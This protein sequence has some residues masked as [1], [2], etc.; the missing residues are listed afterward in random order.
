[1]SEQVNQ[2]VGRRVL[3][4][5]GKLAL[6]VLVLFLAFMFLAT[7][8]G[9]GEIEALVALVFGW[10][11]F[12]QRTVPS[13]TWNWDLV[14]MAALCVVLIA[15][16][17]HRFASWIVTSIAN[18]SGKNWGWPWRWTWCGLTVLGLMF[19][20]GMSVGGA[21]H[22]IGWIAGSQEAWF[23]RK[24][25][26]MHDMIQMRDL[27]REIQIILAETNTVA[28]VRQ[29]LIT[30]DT[31]KRS[32]ERRKI[33]SLQSF[34]VLIVSTNRQQVD[35]VIIFPRAEEVKSRLHGFFVNDGERTEVSPATLPAFIRE[36]EPYLIAF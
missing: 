30:S 13:I 2:Q 22:Q 32:L 3:G 23:E 16:L 26:F 21:A 1:V 9:S 11:T 7:G 29:R 12:L 24:P 27:E 14:G 28:G 6:I 4:C 19:L 33:S 5:F 18:K 31:E 25:R 36:R 8:V 15:L 20:V 17:G 10:I 35:G 34:H